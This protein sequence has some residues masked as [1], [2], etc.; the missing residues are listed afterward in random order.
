[1]RRRRRR[2]ERHNLYRLGSWLDHM[3]LAIALALVVFLYLHWLG[4]ER[5]GGAALLNLAP[6]TYDGETLSGYWRGRM[7]VDGDTI[8]A[9]VIEREHWQAWETERP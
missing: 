1:M 6:V 9:A 7:I 5:P 8:E 4:R 2:Y 3:P